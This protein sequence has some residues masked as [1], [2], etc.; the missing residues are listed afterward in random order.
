MTVDSSTSLSGV[1]IRVP[2][3][4]PSTAP[5]ACGRSPNRTV[6]DKLDTQS[7]SRRRGYFLYCTDMRHGRLDGE[8][9]IIG[10]N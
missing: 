7:G 1:L 6:V 10:G 9:K 2:L 3:C 5:A 8:L 4:G